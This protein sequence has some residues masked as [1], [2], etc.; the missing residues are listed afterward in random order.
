M[1]SRDLIKD[2]AKYA[3]DHWDALS[4]NE[5]S[6]KQSLVLP[7]IQALGY[8][9]FDKMEVDPEFTADIGVKKGEKV[10]YAIIRDGEP[11]ILVE[12][13]AI[14]IS[15]NNDVPQL[16]RYFTPT[17]ARF[18]ALSFGVL[19]NGVVYRFFSDLKTPNAMDQT[20]FLEVDIRS[21]DEGDVAL[22]RQF[23]KDEFDAVKIKE[24]A[25]ETNI[26]TGVKA[27][28][29][30]MYDNPDDAFSKTIF[31]NVGVGD[32]EIGFAAS[33]RELVKR[34]FHEFVGDLSGTGNGGEFSQEMSEGA[35][36][37]TPEK[38]QATVIHPNPSRGEQQTSHITPAPADGWQALSDIQREQGDD[39]PTH[40]RFPDNSVVTITAWNQVA[41]H[42]VRWL[43][44]NNL[45]TAAHCPIQ[46]PRTGRYGSHSR[47]IVATWPVH[48]TGSEF[49][50]GRE[51]NSLYVELSYN[52]P[53][54][55][56]NAKVVIASA[57][58][59]ASQFSVKWDFQESARD[60]NSM[61]N[62]GEFPQKTIPDE[63]QNDPDYSPAG[64][65]LSLSNIQPEQGDVKPT[66][67]TFPDNSVVGITAW[68]Q[69][70]FHTF[71]WLT[72]NYH[73]NAAHCP[74]RRRSRYIVANQPIHPTGRKF[75]LAREVNSL[76]IEL[77]YSVPDTVKI[78]QIIIERAGLDASQFKVRW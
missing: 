34:A 70:T 30:R 61:Q 29:Q 21:A 40:M 55:I 57:G 47:Y 78:A 39:S 56:R 74:I 76:H 51:V 68:N 17:K 10:D 26:I 58:M 50:R 43:T 12:C 6:T 1:L 16:Y 62:G 52:V 42:A 59:D 3:K 49:K 11:I 28:I 20:P 8:N 75:K 4:N 33:H 77:S 2:L 18:G 15:L 63:P 38:A 54:T 36:Q 31:R 14:N 53:D 44:D 37:S 25:V 9:V 66:H 72:D 64:E 7:L 69:V 45:L 41:F 22:L 32:L 5:A 65:W 13:K 19:T 27:N 46:I 23:A 60:H 48:P 67:M 24:A 35:S 73:L 71:R